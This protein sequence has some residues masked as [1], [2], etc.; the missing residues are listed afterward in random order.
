MENGWT[1]IVN[2]YEWWV[3]HAKC[4]NNEKLVSF[5]H[6]N[7][8]LTI[9]S[10]YLHNSPKKIKMLNSAN[11]KSKLLYSLMCLDPDNLHRMC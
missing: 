3:L 5:T 9:S 10:I 6:I 8:P 1:L 11:L 7:P 4:D 2:V